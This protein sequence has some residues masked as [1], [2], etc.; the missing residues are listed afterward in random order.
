MIQKY[1]GLKHSVGVLGLSANTINIIVGAVILVLLAVISTG[2]MLIIY[3]LVSLV[4][5]WLCYSQKRK[6]TE[7]K[8]LGV[9]LYNH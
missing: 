7:I 4:V 6:P 9:L 5:I 1:E 8:I 3:S 2:A